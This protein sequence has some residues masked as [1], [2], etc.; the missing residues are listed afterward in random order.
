[1]CRSTDSPFTSMSIW[2]NHSTEKKLLPH[3]EKH[4]LLLDDCMDEVIDWFA[5][6]ESV[7]VP[8]G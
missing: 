4:D 3:W 5:E 8:T 2:K 6:E 7:S 1:M